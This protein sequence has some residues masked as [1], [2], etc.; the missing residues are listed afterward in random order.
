MAIIIIFR[1]K[2]KG[3]DSKR[4]SMSLK[5]KLIYEPVNEHVNVSQISKRE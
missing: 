5:L 3:D 2:H 4:L 1:V